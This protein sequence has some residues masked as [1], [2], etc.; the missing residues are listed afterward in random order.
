MAA[1][2]LNDCEKNNLPRTVYFKHKGP[3][4]TSR[5]NE[6]RCLFRLLASSEHWFKLTANK[7]KC[8]HSRKNCWYCSWLL[9]Q[10]AWQQ[11]LQNRGYLATSGG[12]QD[13]YLQFFM[14]WKHLH[15]LVDSLNQSS[16]RGYS[17]NGFC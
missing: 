7:C 17:R 9:P 11:D 10:V 6:L 4:T 5:S 15:L 8:F 3:M 2:T 12:S 16:R 14:E 1:G 13:Q